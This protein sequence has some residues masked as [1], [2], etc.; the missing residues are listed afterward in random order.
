VYDGMAWGL[1]AAG[2]EVVEYRW[3]E[4]LA[5][6]NMLITAGVA[7]GMIAPE[8]KEDMLRF[9]AFVASADVLSVA[10]EREVEAVLVINGIL[11]PMQRAALFKKIGL[12][13]ACYGTEAPYLLDRERLISQA[14]SHW[15]TQ[16]RRCVGAFP[17]PSTYLPMAF[18]PNVHQPAPP[19]PEKAVDLVFVGGGYP[20]RKA[21]WDGVDWA[22]INAR[23]L[24]TLWHL[25]EITP[26]ANLSE[27]NIPNA[28]TTR[29]HQSARI[30]LNV[31][32]R[33]AEPGGAPIAPGIAASLGPRPY[34]IAA[35]G[36]LLLSDDERPEIYEV[37]GESAATF[38]AWDSAD[39]GRQ[40]R[41][42]LTHPGRR[43]ETAAA[44]YAA[45][46]S[47]TYEARARTVLE[48][49]TA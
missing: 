11:F 19:D 32:R 47:H 29:W 10:V 36:T 23:R 12:P 1:H 9:A 7:Q 6:L 20:E 43:E 30:G 5:T 16:E 35:C 4:H 2:A 3:D 27:G 18:N 42:W 28:E 46:Q 48:T 17:V 40:A 26:E 8:K 34:E 15:F 31:H 45:V 13:V 21:L 14:Y 49:L 37:F 33:M 39:L 22:G 41:Y 25:N 24:G 38:R 44:Q